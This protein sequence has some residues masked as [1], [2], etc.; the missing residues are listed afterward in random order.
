ME[1]DT[2][3][4]LASYATITSTIIAVFGWVNEYQKRKR[5]QL[6]DRRRVWASISVIK[7]IVSDIQVALKADPDNQACHQ[8][9]GALDD[10]FRELLRE[11]ISKEDKFSIKTIKIWR[12][13]GKL[14]SDWQERIAF[15]LLDTKEMR[16]SEIE[17]IP[18]IFMNW[19]QLES[20]HP[21]S[22]PGGKN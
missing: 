20:D 1:S 8:A 9:H 12:R 4:S 7:G 14:S 18:E 16:N 22:S 13:S 5:D 11:A 17:T 10:L 15:T 19:D 2:L 3:Q 21:A 6:L